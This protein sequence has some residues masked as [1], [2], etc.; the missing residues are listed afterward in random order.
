MESVLD[1]SKGNTGLHADGSVVACA[2]VSLSCF[3]TSNVWKGLRV[4]QGERWE[5]VIQ[6]CC[7]ITNCALTPKSIFF[8]ALHS[9]V[10]HWRN[11]LFPLSN[12]VFC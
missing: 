12:V 8:S 3:I 1:E 11:T 10:Y 9:I 5:E 2:A 7:Y 4:E 6:K